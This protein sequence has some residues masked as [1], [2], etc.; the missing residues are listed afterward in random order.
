MLTYRTGLWYANAC[1]IAQCTNE[2][3]EVTAIGGPKCYLW[4]S[5]AFY[6]F[7]LHNPIRIDCCSRVRRLRD[8]P[9]CCTHA[10]LTGRGLK[11]RILPTQHGQTKWLRMSG[12]HTC[13]AT[14]PSKSQ[15]LCSFSSHA[16]VVVSN[17]YCTS[18]ARGRRGLRGT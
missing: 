15:Y 8:M 17:F 6:A 14:A 11:C 2:S 5:Y 1:S 4:Y 18:A 7:A 12:G 16:Q 3:T 13:Y 10:S 9:T